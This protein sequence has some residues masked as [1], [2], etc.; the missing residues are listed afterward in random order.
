MATSFP[1]T[2]GGT[3]NLAMDSSGDQ[4]RINFKNDGTYVISSLISPSQASITYQGYSSTPGDGGKATIDGTTTGIGLI[5]DT[6]SF[7]SWIDFIFANSATIN[8]TNNFS[9]S[10]N[11]QRA[12]RVVSH[13]A[14]G[15]GIVISAGTGSTLIECEVYACNKAGNA[16]RGGIDVFGGGFATL[17]RCM[18]HD[19]TGANGNGFTTVINSNNFSNCVAYN[20]GNAGFLHASNAVGGLQGFYNCD[21]YNNT[22]DG[23]NI[24]ADTVASLFWIQNCNFIKNG[25]KGINNTASTSQFTQG[26][27]YNCGYG[28]GT[29]ANVGGDATLGA[30]VETGK[31]SY[32]SGVTPYSAPT[33]GNFSITLAAAKNAGRGVFTETDG[34]NSGTVGYPDIGSAQHLDSG[35]GQK[36]YTFG[37]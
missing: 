22:G 29:Q 23:I 10:G 21:A 14:R 36:S 16:N 33:T 3:W 12:I 2:L 6:G 1:F 5:N 17:V 13:G 20:N 32:A 27:V 8:N 4:V 30:F 37:G 11:G 34:T 7:T 18:S 28:T 19:N 15:S 31:V 24:T 35:G 26:F 25:G 9:L